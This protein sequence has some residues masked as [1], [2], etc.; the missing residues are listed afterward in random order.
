MEGLN[1]ENI[2]IQDGRSPQMKFN[3]KNFFSISKK[4]AILIL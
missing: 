4:V 2:N 1:S 3:I